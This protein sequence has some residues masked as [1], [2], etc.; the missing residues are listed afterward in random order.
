M[1]VTR[2][3]GVATNNQL[4]GKTIQSCFKLEIRAIVGSDEGGQRE[5]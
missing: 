3:G 2:G 5:E 4:Q 1:I